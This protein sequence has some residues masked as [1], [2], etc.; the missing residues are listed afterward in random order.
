MGTVV[1]VLAIIGLLVLFAYLKIPPAYASPQ[2]VNVFNLMV[3]GVCALF[4]VAWFFHIR[5]DWM[6]TINDKYWL[7]VAIAGALGIEIVFLGLCFLIRN[8]WLFKPRRP[9]GF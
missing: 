9:G 4:C 7:P 1:V 5:T 6:G 8:F 2:L 3:I